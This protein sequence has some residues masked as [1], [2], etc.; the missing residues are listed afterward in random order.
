MLSFVEDEID[1]YDLDIFDEVKLGLFLDS[2]FYRNKMMRR[3]FFYYPKQNI[4]A[5]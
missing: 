2:R 5:L 3:S 4:W 1:D